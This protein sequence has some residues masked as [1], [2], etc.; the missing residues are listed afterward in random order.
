MKPTAMHSSCQIL[1]LQNSHEPNPLNYVWGMIQRVYH[2]KVQDVS[3]L[4][5]HLIDVWAGVEQMVT[6]DTLP[7]HWC[8]RIHACI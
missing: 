2:R 8:R 1:W 5:Q 7:D 3:D 4:R 6:D